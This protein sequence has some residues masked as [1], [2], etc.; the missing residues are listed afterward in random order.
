MPCAHGLHDSAAGASEWMAETLLAFTAAA[1]T[2]GG[3]GGFAWDH[4]IFAWD[5]PHGT[6]NA[7]A[8]SQWRAWMAIL[9]ELRSRHPA[10]MRS[11]DSRRPKRKWPRRSRKCTTQFVLGGIEN[12]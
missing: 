8:Y 4:D 9:K 12:S 3:F 6:P 2:T 1:N 7:L 5:G 10:M 11:L